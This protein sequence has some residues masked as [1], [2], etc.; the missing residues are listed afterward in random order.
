M[1]KVTRFRHYLWYVAIGVAVLPLMPL[2]HYL[3]RPELER[4]A[5]IALAMILVAIK[6]C[7]DIRDRMWFWVTIVGVAA[8]HVPLVMYTAQR[9]SGI[10]FRAIVYLGIADCLAILAVISLVERLVGSNDPPT[11]PTSGGTKSHS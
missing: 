8:L 10:S 5:P 2:L 1:A 7:R 3:G 9:L 6:V 11:V 4:P